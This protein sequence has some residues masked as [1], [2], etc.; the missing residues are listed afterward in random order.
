MRRQVFRGRTRSPPP[1]AGT[2][3]K[4]LRSGPIFVGP[5]RR[6]SSSLAF[7]TLLRNARFGLDIDPAE[8]ILQENLQGDVLLT[9]EPTLR[10]QA[11]REQIEHGADR[12]GGRDL[13]G[14]Q[15]AAVDVAAVD[16]VGIGFLDQ[17]TVVAAA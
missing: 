11:G 14:A 3:W 7:A 10:Q 6:L 8:P 1:P 15:R 12:G 16:L 13:N 2:G 17:L 5:V 4:A 9:D